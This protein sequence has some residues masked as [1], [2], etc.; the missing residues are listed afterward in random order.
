MPEIQ[1]SKFFGGGLSVPELWMTSQRHSSIRLLEGLLEAYPG[2][3][4]QNDHVRSFKN[5][6]V[7]PSSW[8]WFHLFNVIWLESR[9][10]ILQRGEDLENV[11]TIRHACE[12][13]KKKVLALGDHSL[14]FPHILTAVQGAG[15]AWLTLTHWW[16]NSSIEVKIGAFWNQWGNV[17]D[18]TRPR[19]MWRCWAEL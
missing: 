13:K 6:G 1:P 8:M 16:N 5:V 9:W 4:P 12:K 19:Q 7:S 10:D 2:P 15:P 11:E 17:G 14:F 3:T 18:K